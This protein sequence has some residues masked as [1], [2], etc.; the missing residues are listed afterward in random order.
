MA[1]DNAN[2]NAADDITL[3]NILDGDNDGGQGSAGSIPN[4]DELKA[5][6]EAQ[7]AK[8]LADDNAAEAAR[9]A[10][11]GA[12]DGAGGNEG[13]EPPKAVTID[14]VE[15][16]LDADGNAINDKGEVFKTKEELLAL[17]QQTK[18]FI[19]AYIERVGV[20]ILDEAGKPKVYEDTE[21]GVIEYNK[22]YAE[23][24]AKNNFNAILN[25]NPEFKKYYTYVAQGGNPAD[26]HNE[27]ASSWRNVKY[28]KTNVAF[29]ESVATAR[30]LKSGISEAQ[31]KLTV[32]MYKDSNNLEAFASEAYKAFTEEEKIADVK[33]EEK[34]KQDA[35]DEEKA[36]IAHW[37]NEKKIINQGKLHSIEIPVADREAFFKYRAMA[38]DKDGNSQSTIDNGNLTA[39]QLLQLD[40]IKFK[41]LDLTKLIKAA[42]NTQRVLSLKERIAQSNGSSLAGGGQGLDKG[43]YGKSDGTEITLDNVIGKK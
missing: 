24:Q 1:Q 9:L 43:K 40:Y 23:L 21:E 5:F 41:K 34:F 38:V 2:T 6:Q 27:Q 22:D 20:K 39:E 8:K 11:Q 25:S 4:A 29:L 13:G 3:S 14:E 33:R 30:L 36:N 42:A 10:A 12:G 28:D 7:A 19:E 35:I 17:E 18:P 16:Q 26:Y 31:A 15:Y 37:E 32:G